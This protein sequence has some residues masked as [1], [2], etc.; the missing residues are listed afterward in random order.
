MPSSTR[1]RDEPKSLI[2]PT[3][4]SDAS[5]TPKSPLQMTDNTSEVKVG[6]PETQPV[7]PQKRKAGRKPLYKTAQERRDR[8]RRAQLAFRARRSDYLSRLEDTCRSLETVVLELQE[9]NRAANDE[10]ARE[11]NKVRHLERML[12][13]L[14]TP[15]SSHQTLP[16]G[17]RIYPSAIGIPT[18]NNS[19]NIQ[20]VR[21]QSFPQELSLITMEQQYSPTSANLSPQAMNALPFNQNYLG[22]LPLPIFDNLDP[23]NLV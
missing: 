18:D 5:A 2:P 7:V 20:V 10:L 6:S 21:T 16:D 14:T 23:S 12:R 19:S 4:E 13:R 1:P 11:K 3:P 15:N 17:S 8:N 9:S 22:M